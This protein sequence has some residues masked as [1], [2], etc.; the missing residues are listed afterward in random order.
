MSKILSIRLD[1][2]TEDKPPAVFQPSPQ[3][4]EVFHHVTNYSGNILIEAVAG[5]GK[6][7]VLFESMTLMQGY[8]DYAVYGKKNEIEAQAKIKRMREQGRI[9]T[10]IMAGTFHRFGWS[11]WRRVAPKAQIE[12]YS[13]YSRPGVPESAGYYKWDRIVSIMNGEEPWPGGM[14]PIPDSYIKPQIWTFVKKIVS[15]AK[16][17]ALGLNNTVVDYNDWVDIIN[18]HGLDEDLADEFGAVTGED[19]AIEGIGLA[20]AALKL[21]TFLS[22]EVVDFDDL[23]YM[24]L[25]RSVRVWPN[26][27]VLVDE[28]QDQ[29]PARRF[30]TRKMLKP[31]GR[32]IFV[33]DRH[34]SIMGFTDASVDSMD[35]IKREFR[36]KEL[37]LSVTFRNPKKIV[38]MAQQWVPQ[39]EAHESAP[40]GLYGVISMDT[41]LAIRSFG[42]EDAILCRN[43]APLVSIAFQLIRRGISCYV[44]GRSIGDEILNLA[45]RWKVGN[46]Q[47]LK[48]RA[49]TYKE[50]GV[51]RLVRQKRLG[52]ADTLADRCDTL[53]ALIDGMHEGSTT[54]DLRNRIKTM[55]Q[56]T[57]DSTTRTCVVLSSIHKAKGLEW[58]RVY[59]LGR[60]VLM[61][62]PY[63]RSEWQLEQERNLCYVAITRVKNEL[64]EVNM[65]TEGRK[66]GKIQ[67]RQ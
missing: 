15:M 52:L 41:F 55:F 9:G 4:E 21:S 35:I 39:I 17:R 26:D 38:A 3:Q 32:A 64:V 25:F 46:L 59:L 61:P 44:E 18:H 5:S 13:D 43:N 60:N 45:N 37:P 27:W 6:S 14:A 2:F 47:L 8:V 54:N 28:A 29:N 34:Q 33:G 50:N 48:E 31:M 24:A 58:E 65:S 57:R 7:T 16:Q 36:C 10:N 42:S 1:G 63:A 56:D 53:L 66:G 67:T 11:A 22:R 19:L 40:D 51:K 30:L 62:S 49:I 23:I 12:G 20:Q